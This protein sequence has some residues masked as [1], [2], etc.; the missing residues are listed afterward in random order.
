MSFTKKQVQDIDIALASKNLIIKEGTN[1]NGS[2][3]YSYFKD[4]KITSKIDGNTLTMKEQEKWRLF[5][6]DISGFMNF[7][8]QNGTEK[9][10]VEL[11]LSKDSNLNNIKI[12]TASGDISIENVKAN[13]LALD[14][15]SGNIK[16]TNIGTTNLTLSSVNGDKVL[17][18]I[19][20]DSL[21]IN[22]VSGNV[23]K[24]I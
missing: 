14:V 4:D 5:L 7:P 19:E 24:T 12:R 21:N 2:L 10:Y 3:K 6:V 11:T 20:A 23:T 15:A 13:D 1:E 18:N 17:S 16:L 8:T 9:I 22:S